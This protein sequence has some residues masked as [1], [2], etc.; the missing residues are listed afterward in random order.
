M[1]NR[2][3]NDCYRIVA[4]AVNICSLPAAP[5]TS[6]APA[7]FDESF[8]ELG[9]D[10]LAMMEFCISIHLETGVELTVGKADELGSPGAVARFLSASAA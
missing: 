7:I 5:S 2:S 9:F 6:A 1:T 4:E 3:L 8:G 10:S